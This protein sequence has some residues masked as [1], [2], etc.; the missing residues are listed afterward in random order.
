[1]TTD[2]AEV[3]RRVRM[4]RDHGQSQKYHHEIEGYNGRLDAIQAAFLRVKL[5][6]L[7]VWNAQRRAAAGLYAELLHNAAL[8][9]LAPCE[10]PWSGS[11]YHLY[12]LRVPDRDGLARHLRTSGIHTGIHYPVP[13]HL[14]NCYRDWNYRTGDLPVTER[15]AGEV[16]SLPMYPGLTEKEQRRVIAE[17]VAFMG[18]GATT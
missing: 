15:V 3:A 8:G 13:V 18:V 1:V 12:V 6:R 17:I 11:V 5:R 9:S 14:Q 2:D 4:L 10:A 7:D 16:I